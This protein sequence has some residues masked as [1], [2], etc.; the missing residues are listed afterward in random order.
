[1]VPAL[2]VVNAGAPTPFVPN[3]I[4]LFVEPLKVNCATVVEPA[5]ESSIL[6]VPKLPEPSRLTIAFAVFE[7]DEAN[8]LSNAAFK[9]A[10]SVVDETVNGAVPVAT[11]DVYLVAE[12]APAIVKP[13]E[14]VKVN[15]FV[16]LAFLPIS[17]VVNCR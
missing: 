8:P 13:P 12:R 6:P 9:L 10:T 5:E 16:P 2:L 1:M 14:L 7:V 15:T 11:V 17:S 3:V 4:Q